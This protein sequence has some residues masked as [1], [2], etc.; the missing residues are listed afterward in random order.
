MQDCRIGDWRRIHDGDPNEGRGQKEIGSCGQGECRPSASLSNPAQS[1]AIPKP[2]AK[3]KRKMLFCALL[4]KEQ[5]ARHV[6]DFS[7]NEDDW[8][9]P[10]RSPLWIR[11]KDGDEYRAVDHEKRDQNQPET[12]ATPQCSG[13][14]HDN[15]E[16]D[17]GPGYETQPVCA[18]VAYSKIDLNRDE[19]DN[20]CNAAE[21]KRE[22][23]W[24]LARQRIFLL[25][26]R[27]TPAG[28]GEEV[29]RVAVA[30]RECH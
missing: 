16:E 29:S 21:G 22:V 18:D 7:F 6:E 10:D 3:R 4:A 25:V 27:R 5:H 12:S 8:Y 15:P 28:R 30:T 24:A 2:R 13:V 1:D 20:R 26:T 9:E 14:A 23:K 17:A 11:A 19:P